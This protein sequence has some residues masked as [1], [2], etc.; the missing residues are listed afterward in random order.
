MP[1]LE[2]V[3]PSAVI[4]SRLSDPVSSA[5]CNDGANEMDFVDGMLAVMIPSVVTVAWLVWQAEF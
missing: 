3:R 1:L 4:K 2:L 5:H